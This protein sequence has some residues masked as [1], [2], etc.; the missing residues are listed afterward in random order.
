MGQCEGSP[1]WRVDRNSLAAWRCMVMEHQR[2]IFASISSPSLLNLLK[3][4][5]MTAATYT[6]TDRSNKKKRTSSVSRATGGS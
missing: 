2:K 1:M 5:K 4:V 3:S 6:A